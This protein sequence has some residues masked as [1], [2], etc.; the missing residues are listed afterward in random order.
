MPP[1]N[2]KRWESPNTDVL[3]C[4]V[5]QTTLPW[6]PKASNC[7]PDDDPPTGG[8][9][10]TLPATPR[11]SYS[12]DV[13]ASRPPPPTRYAPLRDLRSA[14]FAGVVGLLA[15]LRCTHANRAAERG[16]RPPLPPYPPTKT[17][18]NIY[19]AGTPTLGSKAAIRATPRL[20][21]APPNRSPRI[22]FCGSP[23][24]GSCVLAPPPASPPDQAHPKQTR[25]EHPPH[26]NRSQPKRVKE[27]PDRRP[28]LY[29][30]NRHH[31]LNE[32]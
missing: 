20:N 6:T 17:R 21:Y 10:T 18:P 26:R 11:M 2:S 23:P 30:E 16:V 22:R 14:P 12:S 31:H 28:Y 4:C 9:Q 1:G 13:D 19:L 27:R 3:G 7:S 15:K 24:L 8:K 25:E 5:Y 29:R 32:P